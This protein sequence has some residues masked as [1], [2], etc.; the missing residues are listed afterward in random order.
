MN[1]ASSPKVLALRWFDELWV[2]RRPETIDALL[3]ADGVGNTEGGVVHGRQQVR[4]ALYE[5]LIRA[6]PDMKVV[7]D[8]CIAEGD[9]AAVRWTV[10]GTQ[11]GELMGI[12]P[13]NQKVTF[14][15]MSWL[16]V[17]DGMIIHGWDRWNMAGL[18]EFL[19]SGAEC[20]TV[21]RL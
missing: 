8:A 3:H 14:S 1:A 19:R 20:A 7:V 21:R 6:F 13:S 5:P 16:Q 11:T 4:D 17:R 18:L 10:T 9:H 15:G 2:R 12:P